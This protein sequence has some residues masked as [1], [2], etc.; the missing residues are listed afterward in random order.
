LTERK[1]VVKRSG[2]RGPRTSITF[3]GAGVVDGNQST[4]TTLGR[5]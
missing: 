1:T 3:S 5:P 2:S 4:F